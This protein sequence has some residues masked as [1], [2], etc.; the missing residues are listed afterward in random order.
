MRFLD[1]LE[2]SADEIP[3][4]LETQ[5]GQD[6]S[7]LR[8][9]LG[10]LGGSNS[11]RVATSD[12]RYFC[13]C[14]SRVDAFSGIAGKNPQ[15]HFDW[16]SFLKYVSTPLTEKFYSNGRNLLPATCATISSLSLSFHNVAPLV[17][18]RSV[19]ADGDSL[20]AATESC[21]NTCRSWSQ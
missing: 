8:L 3:P 18:N 6:I 20:S 13:H 12:E 19:N 4:R 9:V 11:R 16:E 2:V 21:G 7:V 15:G 1:K 17:L 5:F 10:S 14:D